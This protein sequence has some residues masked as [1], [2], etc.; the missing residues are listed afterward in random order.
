MALIGYA[1][2]STEEQSL[3]PQTDALR[4]A[5]CTTLFEEHEVAPD[6][7]TAMMLSHKVIPD[8]QDPSPVCAGVS[9]PDGRVGPSRT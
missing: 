2:V 3:S 6:W 9:A 7:W 5:G 4:A 1:R 8:A